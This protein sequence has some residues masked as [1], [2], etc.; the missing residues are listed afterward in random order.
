MLR[1][2]SVLLKAPMR[3]RVERRATRRWLVTGAYGMAL[4]AV[5]T[6]YTLAY[7]IDRF[8]SKAAF[9]SALLACCVLDILAVG[10]ASYCF[11]RL[12][13][14]WNWVTAGASFDGIDERMSARK[15]QALAYSFW[16]LGFANLLEYILWT[17]RSIVKV[18]LNIS[19]P[20]EIAGSLLAANFFLMFT[21]PVAV[22]GWIEPDAAR[23]DD[24]NSEVD[25]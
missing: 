23:D 1:R 14:N 4:F 13:R 9:G 25:T 10:I 15:N 22:I 20:P 24:M 5:A 3:F 12:A 17:A 7:S 2:T 19:F 18:F 6:F 11:L 21:L 8:S 16:I